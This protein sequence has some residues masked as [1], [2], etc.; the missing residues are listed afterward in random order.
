MFKIDERKNF[1]LSCS[2]HKTTRNFIQ[3]SKQLYLKAQENN[4]SFYDWNKIYIFLWQTPLQMMM[5]SN[6]LLRNYTM[7][8]V[9]NTYYA[10]FMIFFPAHTVAVLCK[11]WREFFQYG[12]VFLVGHCFYHVKLCFRGSSIFIHTKK[13]ITLLFVLL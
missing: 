8:Y 7:Y 3:Y 10:I 13:L 9:P 4:T 6:N 11:G 5:F 12:E 2:L 1:F